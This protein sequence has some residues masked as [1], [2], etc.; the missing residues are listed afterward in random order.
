[1]AGRTSS[2][3][4]G[5]VGGGVLLALGVGGVPAALSAQVTGTDGD[6]VLT[7]TPARDAI[8]GLAGDDVLHGLGSGDTLTDGPGADVVFG[9]RGAD[10]LRSL[11]VQA[12]DDDLLRGGLGP[13]EI[14]AGDG[15]RALGG[16][17]KDL[18]EAFLNRGGLVLRG[19][20]GQDR[21]TAVGA[22][23]ADARLL[24]GPGNDSLDL[25]GLLFVGAG[26]GGDDTVVIRAADRVSGGP[27]N[28]ALNLA[29]AIE[30]E[31]PGGVAR[32]IDGG[33]GDDVI[34]TWTGE[35]QEPVTCGAGIDTVLVSTGQRWT[36]DCESH[37]FFFEGENCDGCTEDD[38]IVGTPDDDWVDAR[39]GADHVETLAGDD[40][41]FLGSG[42]DVAAAGAGNDVV[43]ATRDGAQDVDTVSCGSGF[44]VVLAE[45][46][47]E[48]APDCEVVRRQL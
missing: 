6:D 18:L 3:R 28:D 35:I 8:S 47:D 45:S 24:G 16:P 22:A 5:I 34:Q 46:A 33:R 25:D 30:R 26:G 29:H 9:D 36:A 32:T 4:V 21:L 23:A 14:T 39:E 17:Q 27:G 41:I 11:N 48:I 31:R 15:D 19:G 12:A 42:S 1:M 43:D 37:F 20:A 40:R 2:W 7:G 10:V 13:D 38:H 44:D